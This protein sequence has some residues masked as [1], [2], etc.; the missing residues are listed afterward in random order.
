MAHV[1]YFKHGYETIIGEIASPREL[2]LTSECANISMCEVKGKIKVDFRGKSDNNYVSGIRSIEDRYFYRFNYDI[3][4]ES[5][6]EASEMI[7][8][9][10]GT[11]LE[12]Y[13]CPA[14]VAANR[15]K[16]NQ[17]LKVLD[18]N[19]DSGTATGFIY[20]DIEYHLRDF[21]LQILVDDL[22]DSD[23]MSK[24][25]ER[26][27][28]EPDISLWV[29]VYKRY[30]DYF[31]AARFED[32]GNIVEL[33][34]FDERRVFLRKPKTLNPER[35]D[36]RCF[37]MHIEHIEDLDAYKDLEDTF[38][39]QDHIPQDLIKDSV[40]VEDLQPMP[41]KHFKYSKESKKRLKREEEKVVFQENGTK[42]TTLGFHESGIVG[43]TYAIEFDTAAA[44][45]LKRN[46][47]DAI[48]YN[49]DA[50]KLLQ[51][52]V[53]EEAC[54]NAGILYDMENNAL[55][56]MPSIGDIQ[57]IIGGPRVKDGVHWIEIRGSGALK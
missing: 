28:Y 54:L 2:F 33:T 53:N 46:F 48:V 6:T 20:Q 44:K 3:L 36:G 42:L 13:D 24:T 50:N 21:I 14:R 5:F 47:P 45:T 55:L 1:R 52:A 10:P 39:V 32:I 29:D 26:E 31:Q 9:N 8:Q 12:N 23:S 30:D 57:M 34:T 25:D 51:W 7:I 4:S 37:V 16:E 43:T 38:W 17:S 22:E 11:T 18:L 56:K 49:H 19:R 27:D 40:S 35:L 41:R 15:R